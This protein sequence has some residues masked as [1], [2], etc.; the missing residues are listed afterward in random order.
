MGTVQERVGTVQERVRK[1]V[2]KLGW[3]MWRKAVVRRRARLVHTYGYAFES[4][5]VAA[6]WDGGKRLLCKQSAGFSNGNSQQ[7][8]QTAGNGLI[9]TGL[10]NSCQTFH[11]NRLVM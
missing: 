1:W 3:V 8:R 11:H 7:S 6:S 4:E 10:P 2:E 9:L 5:P